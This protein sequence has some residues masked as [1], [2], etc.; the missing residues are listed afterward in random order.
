MTGCASKNRYLTNWH[1]LYL[2]KISIAHNIY[3]EEY[4]AKLE[5]KSKSISFWD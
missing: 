1:E 2:N 3:D 4:V 5:C